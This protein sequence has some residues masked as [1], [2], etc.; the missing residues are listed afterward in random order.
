MDLVDHPIHTADQQ[1]MDDIY[2][3][4]AGRVYSFARN[5]LAEEDAVDVMSEVFCAAALAVRDDNVDAVTTSWLMAVTRNKVYDHWR[6]AYRRK[7]KKHL[8]Q[9][10]KEDHVTVPLDWYE[11]PRRP[12]VVSALDRLTPR[13]RSLLVLHHIDGMSIAELAEASGETRRAIESALA[14]ARRRFA[15][16]YKESDDV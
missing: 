8:V 14:R 3:A 10:R 15:T 12:R 13:H 6:K 4:N 7:A 9:G 16:L 5:R 1:L 11:D 2:R